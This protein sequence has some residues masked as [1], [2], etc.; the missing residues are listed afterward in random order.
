MTAPPIRREFAAIGLL[1]AGAFLL[2]ALAFQTPAV[3]G[4][5]LEAAGPFGPLGTWARCALVGAVGVPGALLVGA[6]AIAAALVLFGRVAWPDG[7]RR[8]LVLGTG[9]VLLV[10]V[11]IALAMGGDAPPAAS[12]AT[13]VVGAFVAHY[14]RKAM[15][16]VGAWLA[17]LLALSTVTVVSLRW[18]PLRLLVGSAHPAAGEGDGQRAA[19]RRT[20]AQQLEPDP[21]DLP[22]VDPALARDAL[23]RDAL[24][25]D[26][27]GAAAG[28]GSR[29]GPAPAG[30]TEPEPR[31]RA[32]RGRD[33]A[34]SAAVPALLDAEEPSPVHDE[35]L[36][37]TALLDAPP[38]ATPTPGGGSWMRPAS[39]SSPPS[40][41]SR[42]TG[43]WWD[44]PPAPR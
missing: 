30:A 17:W 12:P 32:K 43:S 11:A 16:A 14:L 9:L 2:G 21:A 28:A 27:L 39:A 31:G 22:A 26:A 18:N 36:P 15:G 1:L 33:K 42:W 10:P 44:A 29:A 41:P 5:C 25:R 3:G 4:A 19:D 40:A 20:L 6:G 7:G 8:A 37:P 24:A 38:R 35:A 34:P 23:A 13:G